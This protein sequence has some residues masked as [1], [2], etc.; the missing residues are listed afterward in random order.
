MKLLLADD[1]EIFRDGIRMLIEARTPHRIVC[2][3][4]SGS[5]IG[6]LVQT[7]A[8]DLAVLDYQMPGAEI[9]AVTAWLKKRFPAIK[10]VILTGATS[11]VLH[12]RLVEAGADAVLPKAGD[13]ETL[14][15]A[16]EAV[17]AGRQVLPQAIR[18]GIAAGA[19][20]LSLTQREYQVLRL[21]C[22]GLGNAEIAARFNL[23]DRTIAKHR[24][25]LFRKLGVGSAAQAINRAIELGLI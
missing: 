7:H 23:S 19:E 2:E 13:A 3:T 5:E 17:A 12:A 8:P 25:N 22:Q 9:T 11:G 20:V 15:K 14:L 6:R 4:A 24:E 16:L 10:V 21:V 18:E 1:H